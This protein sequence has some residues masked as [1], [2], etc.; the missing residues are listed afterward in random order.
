M[1]G[2]MTGPVTGLCPVVTS[3]YSPAPRM[4]FAVNDIK[5]TPK[6]AAYT[7]EVEEL[8]QRLGRGV[9][10]FQVPRGMDVD[11]EYYRAG[12]DLFF[13]GSL[14]GEIV[15]TCARCLEEYPFPLDRRF[16]FVLTP[17]AAAVDDSEAA[18]KDVART[19][20]EGEEVDLTPL[21]YE[22]ALL[23]LPTRPLCAETC[24][25]LCPRCGA[26]LNTAPCAC[27]A[28]G[29]EPRRGLVLRPK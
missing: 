2:Q 20:Y 28:T 8:N 9:Q 7:E 5:A 27:P 11:V 17:R 25:G 22:E 6:H 10:D 18:E 12:L 4:K 21:V 24:R 29:S 13:Q 1:T 3:R 26:N 16:G 23:A 15:G 19:T 14:R